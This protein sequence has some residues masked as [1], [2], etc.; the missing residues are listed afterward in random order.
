MNTADRLEQEMAFQQD[1]FASRNAE[2]GDNWK[3]LGGIAMF[4]EMNAKWARLKRVIWDGQGVVKPEEIKDWIRDLNLYGDLLLFC[5]E[6]ENLWGE[7][8]E[9]NG[10]PLL[11]LYNPDR[12]LHQ[13]HPQVH[14]DLDR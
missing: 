6:D 8:Y 7:G 13:T 1:L 14:G 12:P 10:R 5:I 11:G 3:T 4:V 2:Y 9:G